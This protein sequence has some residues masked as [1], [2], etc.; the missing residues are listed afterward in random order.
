MVRDLTTACPCFT[1]TLSHAQ[2]AMAMIKALT[3]T[4]G[5]VGALSSRSP[6]CCTHLRVYAS[7]YYTRRGHA[8]QCMH[9][10]MR[11]ADLWSRACGF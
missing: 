7:Y 4:G 2:V 6:R 1:S 8:V 5:G 3:T 11:Y 10:R 9:M